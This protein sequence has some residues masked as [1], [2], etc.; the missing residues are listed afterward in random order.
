[1]RILGKRKRKE[2][3]RSRSISDRA[4]SLL[5]TEDPVPVSFSMKPLLE[6]G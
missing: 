6:L 5:N 4:F 2:K 3:T 1:M